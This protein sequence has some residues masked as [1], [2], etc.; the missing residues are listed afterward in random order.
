MFHTSISHLESWYR[1]T[2]RLSFTEASA[3]TLT[4]PLSRFSA[5][6]C[7]SCLFGPVPV[8]EESHGKADQQSQKSQSEQPPYE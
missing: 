7:F 3:E 4:E 2:L 8:A 1:E 5:L 6:L